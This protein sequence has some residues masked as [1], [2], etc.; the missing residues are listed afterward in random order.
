[1]NVTSGTMSSNVKSPPTLLKQLFKTRQ[2]LNCLQIIIALDVSGW[3]CILRP[4]SKEA[5]TTYVYGWGGGGK[6]FV[7]RSIR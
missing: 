6:F 3:H 7:G 1:M 2:V 5:H 4:S